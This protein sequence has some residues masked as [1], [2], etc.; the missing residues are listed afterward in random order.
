LKLLHIC[1][2]S[3]PFLANTPFPPLR[4]VAYSSAYSCVLVGVLLGIGSMAALYIEVWG[5]NLQYLPIYEAL[6]NFGGIK[7]G[8]DKVFFSRHLFSPRHVAKLSIFGQCKYFPLPFFQ[9]IG[10]NTIKL[11]GVYFLSWK[12]SFLGTENSMKKLLKLLYFK[13]N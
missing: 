1:H 10:E 8:R 13:L 11:L 2:V 12:S 7:Q 9:I 4:T 5:D 6:F 3:H